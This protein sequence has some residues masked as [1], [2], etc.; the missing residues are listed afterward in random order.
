M[1]KVYFKNAGSVSA[2][3]VANKLPAYQFHLLQKFSD[4]IEHAVFS[5][6]GGVSKGPYASLNVRFGIGDKLSSVTKNRGVICEAL[7]VDFGN[8]VSADQTH[9]K[10][11]AFCSRSCANSRG[12]RSESFKNKVR[13][14]YLQRVEQGYDNNKGKNRV[15]RIV[16]SC[17]VCGKVL[18]LLPWEA[19]VNRTCRTKEC[20]IG[21]I[22]I[23][24]FNICI[25]N[26]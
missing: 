24:V 10:N 8:L 20:G 1:R 26:I 14:K 3:T 2:R 21:T 4:Q 23:G 9:S 13:D 25:C 12:P 15:D 7:V 22:I 18:A 19:K 17:I 11:G 6:D 16:A 5:R